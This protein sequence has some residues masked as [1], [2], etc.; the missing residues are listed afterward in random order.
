MVVFKVVGKDAKGE[1]VWTNFK[2]NAMAESPDSVLNKVYHDAEGNKVPAAFA[3]KLAR[4]SRLK[5]SETRTIQ[6]EVPKDV[7]EAE[8]SLVYFLLPPPL[9]KKLEIADKPEAKPKKIMSVTAK[10]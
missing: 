6:Y 4:D 2:D 7:V 9:A 8:A 10:R 1:V 3:V 5:P